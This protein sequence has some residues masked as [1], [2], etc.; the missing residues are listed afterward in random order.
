MEQTPLR[1]TESGTLE[2]RRYWE[3]VQ[4]LFFFLSVGCV[5]LL[6]LC[7]YLTGVIPVSEILY[8][9]SP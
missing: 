8:T 6:F 1:F 3:V 5:V 2:G 9:E 4:W 7:F